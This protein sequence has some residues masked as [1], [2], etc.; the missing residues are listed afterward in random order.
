M[1][2]SMDKNK[3]WKI[4]QIVQAQDGWTAVRC[5]ESKNHETTI[6]KRPS[7]AGRLSKL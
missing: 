4:L 7:S 1:K 3:N 5:Q 6:V 2:G